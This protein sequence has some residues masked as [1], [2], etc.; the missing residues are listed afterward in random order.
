MLAASGV[1][2]DIALA[3]LHRNPPTEVDFAKQGRIPLLFLGLS[4]DHVVPPKAT[5]TTS[6]NTTT[7][8]R[9]PST[10]SSRA[11]RTSCAPGRKRSPTSRSIGLSVTR[12]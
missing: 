4:E 1:L 6:G 9:S 8:S 2:A 5:L 7:P 3:N 10:G 11:G 12:G